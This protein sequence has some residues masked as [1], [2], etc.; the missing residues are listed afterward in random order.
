MKTLHKLR[1][2]TRESFAPAEAGRMDV[3]AFSL[4]LLAV[5]VVPATY[6]IGSLV[7]PRLLGPDFGSAA[8]LSLEALAFITAALTLLSRAR[9]RSSGRLTIPIGAMIGIA[10]L[11]A[12]QLLPLP[13]T[14]LESVAP[15]NAGIYHE[16]AEILSLFNGKPPAPRIS[17]APPETLAAI[18]LTLAYLALFFSAVNLLRSKERRRLLAL[19]FFTVAAGQIAA[20]VFQKSSGSSTSGGYSTSSHFAAYLEIALALGFGAVWAELLTNRDRAPRGATDDADRFEVRFL[21]LVGRALVWGTLAFGI[22]RTGS[23]VGALAAAITTLT[24]LAIAVFHRRVHLRRRGIVGS[25]LALLAVGLVIATL[26]GARPLVRFLESDPRGLGTGARVALWRT[27]YHAWQ[28]FPWV[29]SGLGTFP[30]AVRRVQPRELGGRI[31][32]ARSDPLQI[33][34]T[35][36]VVGLALSVLLYGSLFALLLRGFREQPHREESALVLGGFGALM[37]VALHG[38]LDFTYAVP[39]VPAMLACVVG[40]AWAAARRK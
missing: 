3:V 7:F 17:I 19:L 27:A 33:L 34:V 39:V 1:A 10:A 35:G 38:V 4:L 5:L 6:E 30:E 24:L 12:V 20:A 13:R 28:E 31:E 26:A 40:A 16:T 23:R 37:S 18:L 2:L 29:G 36:G 25:L 8:D 32:N 14:I 11:G 9:L 15:V 22:L 21:P